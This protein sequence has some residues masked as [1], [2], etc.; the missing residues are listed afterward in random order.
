MYKKILSAIVLS[1][2]LVGQGQAAD[3]V[4]VDLSVLD[5]IPQD[6]IGFVESQ[7]L[8]PIVKKAG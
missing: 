8:F 1:I 3:D 4:Y 6:S 7:P 2:I 5:A